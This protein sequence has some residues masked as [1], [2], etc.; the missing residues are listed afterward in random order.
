MIKNEGRPCPT[1]EKLPTPYKSLTGNFDNISI[2]STS[3][4]VATVN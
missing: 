4:L 1:I 2:R 3:Q